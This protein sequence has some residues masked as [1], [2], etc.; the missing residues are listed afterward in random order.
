MNGC[1]GREAELYWANADVV[2]RH[3][4]KGCSARLG[5]ELGFRLYGREGEVIGKRAGWSQLI[6]AAAQQAAGY[7]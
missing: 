6:G 3:L 4:L 5:K 7:E 1:C 2:A